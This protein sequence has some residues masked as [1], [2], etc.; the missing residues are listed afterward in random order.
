VAKSTIVENYT[1][2]H[3]TLTSKKNQLTIVYLCR[4]VGIAR[5]GYDNWLKT[6]DKHDSREERDKADYK[7]MLAA[8]NHRGY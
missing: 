6:K 2:I 3:E 7:L 1:L 8:F 4:S 5:S